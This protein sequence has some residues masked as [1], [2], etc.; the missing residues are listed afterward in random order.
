MVPVAMWF[1]GAQRGVGEFH[2]VLYSQS[3][4]VSFAA[5]V[6]RL[7]RREP[8]E[9]NLCE[10]TPP[11]NGG[12]W[13]RIGHVIKGCRKRLRLFDRVQSVPLRDRYLRLGKGNK[14]LRPNSIALPA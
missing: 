12:F 13:N 5:G 1:L 2:P 3:N 11:L 8:L 7:I 14:V 10:V 6:R 4:Q 9:R